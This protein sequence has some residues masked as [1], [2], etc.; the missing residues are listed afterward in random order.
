MHYLSR[1]SNL[2]QVFPSAFQ[3]SIMLIRLAFGPAAFGRTFSYNNIYITSIRIYFHGIFDVGFSLNHSPKAPDN[4][5]RAVPFANG[6]VLEQF[7]LLL[8]LLSLWSCSFR[9]CDCD[10]AGCLFS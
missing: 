8:W 3:N 4:T 7:L 9:Q 1:K 5:V 10:R 6:A 2:Q